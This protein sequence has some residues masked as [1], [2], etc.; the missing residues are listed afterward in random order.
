MADYKSAN[1]FRTDYKS[2]RTRALRAKL[3]WLFLFRWL[4]FVIYR[5][6]MRTIFP[7]VLKAFA[8]AAFSKKCLSV[9]GLFEVER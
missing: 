2:L 6:A 5:T 1:I 4:Q 3:C 7:H 9:T 8:K